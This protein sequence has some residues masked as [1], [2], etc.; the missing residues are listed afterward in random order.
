[1]EENKVSESQKAAQK[2]YDQKTKM[3]SVKY[4]PVDMD[5]YERLKT[6]L[7]KTGK[8][9]NKFIKDLVNDFFESGK[10]EIYESNIEK[11]YMEHKHITIM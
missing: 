1:M 2:K 7:G 6:Y 5:E 4:T 3:I 8:S 10:G 9:T 11:N